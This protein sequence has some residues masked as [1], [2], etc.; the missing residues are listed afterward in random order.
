MDN[1]EIV[2]FDNDNDT[3][4]NYVEINVCNTDPEDSDTD[5][6]GIHYLISSNNFLDC[7]RSSSI[8][9]LYNH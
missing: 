2:G 5:D 8:S 6:D 9:K 3:L 4:A 1:L 7:F